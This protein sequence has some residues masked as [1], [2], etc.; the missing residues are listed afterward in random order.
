MGAKVR[1]SVYIGEKAGYWQ[2]M[3]FWVW[4]GYWHLEMQT[5]FVSFDNVVWC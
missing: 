3:C 5:R 2:D 4:D 1:H